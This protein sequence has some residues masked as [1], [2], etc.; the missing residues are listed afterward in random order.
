MNAV[1]TCQFNSIIRQ[2]GVYL[3]SSALKSFIIGIALQSLCFGA[4]DKRPPNIVIIL[5][6]DFGVGDIHALYPSNKL[7][8][9]NLDRLVSQGMRFTDAHSGSAVCTP[10]RYGILT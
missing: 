8:T 3:R 4:S 7:A 6:D 9:P 10:T 2:I 5:A 1:R